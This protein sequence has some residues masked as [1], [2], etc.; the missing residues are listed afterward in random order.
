MNYLQSKDQQKNR[1]SFILIGFLVIHTLFLAGCETTNEFFL[2]AQEA[3]DNNQY[4]SALASYQKSLQ[5]SLPV[6]ERSLAESRIAEIRT[7]LVDEALA[8]AGYPLETYQKNDL[9]KSIRLIESNLQYDDARQRLRTALNNLRSKLRA[10]E[11]NVAALLAEAVANAMEANFESAFKNVATARDMDP[12][13]PDGEGTLNRIIEIRK[14]HYLETLNDALARDDVLAAKDIFTSIQRATPQFEGNFRNNARTIFEEGERTILPRKINS[15]VNEKR[16][17]EAIQSLEATS[18]PAVSK[19]FENLVDEAVAFYRE[20][21]LSARREVPQ[22]HGVA[23][24]ASRLAYMLKAEDPGL[25]E[26]NQK[27]TERIDEMVQSNIGITSFNSPENEPFAGRDFSDSLIASL[28]NRLPYGIN[29]LERSMMDNAKSGKPESY[30]HFILNSN[31]EIIVGGGISSF[32]V[33]SK[34]NSGEIPVRINVGEEPRPNPEYS[35]MIET[36]GRDLSKWP[37]SVSPTIMSPLFETIRYDKTHETMEGQMSITL[38]LYDSDL[39]IIK[40]KELVVSRN[41]E[42]DY[43]QAVPIAGIEEDKRELPGEN[44]IKQELRSELRDKVSAEILQ[45]YNDREERFWTDFQ[46]SYKNRYYGEAFT[47]L[48]SGYHF[49]EK[50]IE[51]RGNLGQE[52]TLERISSKAFFELANRLAAFHRE[53][54]AF[55]DAPAPLPSTQVQNLESPGAEKYAVII[56]ISEYR[57]DNIPDLNFADNDAKAFYNYLVDANGSG[58]DRD[59]VELLINKDATTRNIRKAFAQ[60]LRKAQEQDTVYIFLA[61]HGSPESP[62]NASE[63]FVLTHDTEFDAVSSTAYPMDELSRS[64]KKYVRA[65]NMFIITDACHSGGIGSNYEITRRSMARDSILSSAHNMQKLIIGE[66]L[67]QNAPV[68]SGGGICFLSASSDQQTSQE[69]EEFGGG[70]GVFTYTLIR[71]LRGLADTNADKLITLSE[72]LSYVP[73][74]VAR[75]TNNEQTP[76]VA[77]NYDP[78][79]VIGRV[80]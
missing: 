2:N 32:E 40:S 49:C 63:L 12:D 31:T 18:H 53:E 65:R 17:Y 26:L 48:A 54:I 15:L 55:T 1:V 39:R 30:R 69:G 27:N 44:A 78:L 20:L 28:V 50:D 80:P 4:A 60:F 34:V 58:F 41:Y 74:E 52:T 10:L 66:Q 77:G 21:A 61:C 19:Q 46:Q 25:F 67:D 29:I 72:I 8:S 45:F 43:H 70:H 42:D 5:Q 76:T 56:G 75:A 7:L 37:K 3:Y 13:H 36:Y 62:E 23:F 68:P 14:S 71:G 22:E 51:L 79:M 59:N 64:L 57:D 35:M 9:I 16:Y 73:A 33:T 24:F 11:N 38:T 47:A 6:R